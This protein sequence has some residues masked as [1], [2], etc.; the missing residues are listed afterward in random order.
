ME[1]YLQNCPSDIYHLAKG[2]R[3]ASAWSL[4]NVTPRLKDESEQGGGVGYE[5][6]DGVSNNNN[7]VI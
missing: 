6:K 7:R 5:G 2:L 4:E 1:Y 3:L